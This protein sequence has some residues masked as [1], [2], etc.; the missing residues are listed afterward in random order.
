MSLLYKIAY[1]G[2]M[3]VLYGGLWIHWSR[4]FGA[5]IPNGSVIIGRMSLVGM[6]RS[7]SIVLL[8]LHTVCYAMAII[9][10]LGQHQPC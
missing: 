3:Y 8:M 9:G 4:D 7:D 1:Y 6:G 2:H 5:T 10:P